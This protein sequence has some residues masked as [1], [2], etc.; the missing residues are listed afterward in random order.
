[1][2]INSLLIFTNFA[3]IDFSATQR[4]RKWLIT[5]RQYFAFAMYMIMF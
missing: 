1:M 3:R 2:K 4:A 5:R